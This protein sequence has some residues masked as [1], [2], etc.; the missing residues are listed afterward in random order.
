MFHNKKSLKPF[1]ALI[2]LLVMSAVGGTFAYFSNGASFENIFIASPYNVSFEENF[3]SPNN[4][5]PGTTTPKSVMVTNNTNVTEDEGIDIAVRFSMSESWVAYNGNV[6]SGVVT[7]EA[8]GE[9]KAAIINLG[10]GIDYIK[11]NENGIDYYYYNYFVRPGESTSRFIESVT[12][13]SNVIN[14]D[15]CV[16]ETVY[17]ADGVTIKGSKVVCTTSGAG[18]DNA[19][20]TLVVLA[21]TVQADSY[22]DFWDTSVNIVYNN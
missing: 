4:W 17:E 8:G 18:Y 3:V 2:L 7:N 1:I 21:E 16:T 11:S 5:I 15:N 10:A 12:F 19:T 9:E 20:Y 22:K 6:L 14:N 13:N